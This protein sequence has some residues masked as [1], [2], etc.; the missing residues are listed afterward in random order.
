MEHATNVKEPEFWR[1]A[2]NYIETVNE[3]VGFLT[4][5]AVIVLGGKC[6]SAHAWHSECINGLRLCSALQCPHGRE[7]GD[8][9]A[10]AMTGDEKMFRPL[11]ERFLNRRSNRIEC[12]LESTMSV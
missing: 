10:K 5:F 11:E 3:P 2:R 12:G 9:S 7:G 8:C 1:H 6:L 4:E